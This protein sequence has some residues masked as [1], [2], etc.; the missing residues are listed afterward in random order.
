VVSEVEDPLLGRIFSFQ[1]HFPTSKMRT[2]ITVSLL[3]LLAVLPCILGH[4]V[5]VRRFI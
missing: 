4:A 2:A 5:L 3:V 1:R